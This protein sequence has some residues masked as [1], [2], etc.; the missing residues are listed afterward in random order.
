MM[1]FIF[2]C[3]HD[4]IG[5][6]LCGMFKWC[7]L[8]KFIFSC[9]N[10]LKL[11]ELSK[12]LISL[13]LN[14]TGD[15]SMGSQFGGHKRRQ[16]ISNELYTKIFTERYNAMSFSL[17]LGNI[18]RWEPL[19][20]QSPDYDLNDENNAYHFFKKTGAQENMGQTVRV[21]VGCLC[22][23]VLCAYTVWMRAVH[24]RCEY[25]WCDAWPTCD[26]WM[27]DAH[28]ICVTNVDVHESTYTYH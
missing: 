3:L 28:E 11:C 5:W 13:L 19:A 12:L 4:V 23:C 22:E 2:S 6:N 7:E 27:C 20:S 1:E 21:S 16:Y 9:W 14:G 26:Q 24:I 17:D 15:V 18:C 8:S 10:D 25:V